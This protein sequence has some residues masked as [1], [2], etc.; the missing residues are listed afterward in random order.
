MNPRG[1]DHYVPVKPLKHLRVIKLSPEYKI[2]KV[3]Y[4]EKNKPSYQIK[5]SLFPKLIIL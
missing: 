4:G 2:T 1:E 3:C 5:T